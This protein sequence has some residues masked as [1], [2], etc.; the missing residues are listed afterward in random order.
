MPGKVVKAPEMVNFCMI[1]PM[2]AE[3]L[4]W[5]SRKLAALTAWVENIQ[6]GYRPVSAGPANP[7]NPCGTRA[8]P[9]NPCG[10]R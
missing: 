5:E 9:C 7:C 2:A 10:A 1:V 4:D 3:P 6:P 8:N